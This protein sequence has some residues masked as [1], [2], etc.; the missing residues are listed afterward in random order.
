[1]TK[2]FDD[3]ARQ[4]MV[5]SFYVDDFKYNNIP[6]KEMIIKEVDAKFARPFISTF[7]YSKTLPDSSKYIYAG[8]L[9][10]KLCGIIVY[11]MGCGKNQYTSLF[12]DIKN[13]QYIELTRLWCADDMP[14]NTES[15]LISGSLKL[16]PKEIKFVLSFSDESRGHV[17]II[18]QA[19]N[20]YYLGINNGGKML[21]TKDGI[22]KH[23]RLIGI[24][25]KRHPE[26]KN[27]TNNYIMKLCG[28]EYKNGGKKHRYIY[29]RGNK[30]AKKEM[31]EHIKGMIKPY[32]KCDKAI[33]KNELQLINELSEHDKQTNIFDF[34]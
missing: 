13:G 2:V 20:W 22:E 31:Y 33:G 8:F 21:I 34:I 15:K 11:G 29:L 5:D 6:I 32:P 10:D 16:L 19:T 25:K 27:K 12:P 14:K 28:Y 23:P 30:K 24:Y 4:K 1:M 3:I 7:H 17:G 18:Y 9:N 26:L